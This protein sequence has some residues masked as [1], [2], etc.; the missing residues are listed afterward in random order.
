MLNDM[1]ASLNKRVKVQQDAIEKAINLFDKYP[2]ER[3]DALIVEVLY[4]ALDGR[5]YYESDADTLA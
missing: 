2:S 1:A 3:R 5:E 4:A